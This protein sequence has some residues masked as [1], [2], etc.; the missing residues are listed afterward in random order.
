LAVLALVGVGALLVYRQRSLDKWEQTL[1]VGA[2]GQGQPN[3]APS[4]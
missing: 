4:S 2:D 3:S 1:G